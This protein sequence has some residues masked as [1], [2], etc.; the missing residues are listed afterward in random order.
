MRQPTKSERNRRM[1]FMNLS[2]EELSLDYGIIKDF[3]SEAMR[4]GS[5]D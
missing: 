4:I 3:A 2:A 5:T 1:M